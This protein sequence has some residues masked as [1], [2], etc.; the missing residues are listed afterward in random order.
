MSNKICFVVSPIGEAESA[1][2]KRADQILRHVI[3]P[4]V[5]SAGYEAIRA[6]QISEPGIITS[7]IIQHICDD[8]LVIA[9]LTGQN[10]NVFYELAIRHVIKR[11]FIQI[12]QKGE[13]IPFDIAGARTIFVDH[14]DLDSVDSACTEILNQIESIE[15]DPTNI[16]T[17]V[18]VALDLQLLRSSGDPRTRS[19]ADLIDGLSEI[20]SGMLSVQKQ[21]EFYKPL[22]E[23]VSQLVSVTDVLSKLSES[24]I[25][26]A[27]K[28]EKAISE[29]QAKLEIHDYMLETWK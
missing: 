17:P 28:F 8:P 2:R 25:V 16:E 20:K 27:E 23:M 14:H 26:D 12:I 11:P 21:L 22:Y 7:Q 19:I 5:S 4:A 3:F 29:I 18:S 1:I 13:Q 15:K 9:D 10:A 24:E 6:D